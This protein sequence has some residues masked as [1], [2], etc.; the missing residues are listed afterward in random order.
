MGMWDTERGSMG[1]TIDFLF[2]FG[3]TIQLRL[4][5]DIKLSSTGGEPTATCE[6]A[7]A[8]GAIQPDFN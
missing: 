8:R 5:L 4:G 7:L 2:P 1:K 6:G 3:H